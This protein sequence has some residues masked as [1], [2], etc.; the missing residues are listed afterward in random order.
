VVV[1]EAF[2]V[3]DVE[4]GV[5]EAAEANKCISVA[6]ADDEMT[7]KRTIHDIDVDQTRNEIRTIIAI[8]FARL[9][10]V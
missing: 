9:N 2:G 8:T 6:L 3:V 4:L 1:G 5:G 7:V 10:I